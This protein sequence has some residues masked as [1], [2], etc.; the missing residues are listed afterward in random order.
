MDVTGLPEIEVKNYMPSQSNDAALIAAMSNNR[1][2]GDGMFGGG[3][4]LGGL[5]FGALL[6]GRG[7]FGGFGGG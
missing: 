6:G 5:L 1:H 2:T 7:G 3:G 4:M